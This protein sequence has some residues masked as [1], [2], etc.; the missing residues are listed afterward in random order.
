MFKI[1]QNS[2]KC[3]LA[4]TKIDKISREGHSPCLVSTSIGEG[5]T[6]SPY[7]TPSRCLVRPTYE[8]YFSP[9]PFEIPGSAPGPSP[10]LVPPKTNFS[11]VFTL[12]GKSTVWVVKPHQTR[13][14]KICSTVKYLGVSNNYALL[15]HFTFNHG[16]QQHKSSLVN[17]WR[18]YCY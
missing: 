3:Y 14:Q 9:P 7:P 16:H 17:I 5:H 1:C 2:L 12:P 15:F 8:F 18:T 11:V 6:P 13:H 10:V 4:N